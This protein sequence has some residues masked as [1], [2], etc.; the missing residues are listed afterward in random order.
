MPDFQPPTYQT[1]LGTGPLFG[2]FLIDEPS[3]LIRDADGNWS[4]QV[5]PSAWQL[6]VATAY[7]LGGYEY[8]LPPSHIQELIAQG[9]SDVLYWRAY[10]EGPYGGGDYGG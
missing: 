8:A 1:A 2:R 6:D 4:V 3:S 5:E 9:L 10:G 7:Y